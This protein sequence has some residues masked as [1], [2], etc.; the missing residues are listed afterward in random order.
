[1]GTMSGKGHAPVKDLVDRILKSGQMT[2][3]D[4]L[5]ITSLL[6]SAGYMTDKERSQIN[7]I[8]DCSQTGRLKITN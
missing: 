7:Y 3:Q 8:L 6:L 1:M 2:R 5:Q 4:H